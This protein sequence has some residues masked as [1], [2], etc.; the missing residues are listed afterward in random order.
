MLHVKLVGQGACR[1]RIDP[2]GGAGVLWFTVLMRDV[3]TL[4][5]Q[6]V[7]ALITIIKLSVTNTIT[8]THGGNAT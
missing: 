6:T 8:V 7:K 2:V 4:A 5:W 3:R 1:A